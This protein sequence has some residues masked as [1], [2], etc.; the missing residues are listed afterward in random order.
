MVPRIARLSKII[1]QDPKGIK[2]QIRHGY[3]C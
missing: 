1:V 2:P 3:S